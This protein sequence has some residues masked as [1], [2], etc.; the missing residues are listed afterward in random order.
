MGLRAVRPGKTQAPRFEQS[1]RAPKPPPQRGDRRVSRRR[2]PL[3]PVRAFPYTAL[4]QNLQRLAAIGIDSVHSGQFFI[5]A[6]GADRAGLSS[7]FVIMN[8]TAAMITKSMTA[9]AKLPM[10]RA[11]SVVLPAASVVVPRTNFASRQLPTV[12]RG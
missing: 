12:S 7:S 6:G 4:Q 11:F 3:V 2:R 5:A 10:V 9:P 1:E 8:T